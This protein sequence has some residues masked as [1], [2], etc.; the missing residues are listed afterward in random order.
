MKYVNKRNLIK[1]D[2]FY[3]I[4]VLRIYGYFYLIIKNIKFYIKNRKFKIYFF[5]L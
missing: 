5:V 2:F 4:E 1:F 3:K